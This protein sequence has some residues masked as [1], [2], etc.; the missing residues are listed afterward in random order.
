MRPG[1]LEYGYER[2]SHTDAAREKMSAAHRKRLGI[3]DGYCRVYGELVSTERA[4][5]LR[6]YARDIARL[7][8]YD[9]A[10]DFVIAAAKSNLPIERPF[11]ARRIAYGPYLPPREFSR[12]RQLRRFVRGFHITVQRVAG[13]LGQRGDGTGPKRIDWELVEALFADGAT[14]AEVVAFLGR[15]ATSFR[16]LAIARGLLH[17]KKRRGRRDC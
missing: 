17:P 2:R 7:R 10:R 12:L 13:T 15:S 6:T 1:I 3:P 9:A 8:G 16:H 5:P 14:E 11:P 4:E